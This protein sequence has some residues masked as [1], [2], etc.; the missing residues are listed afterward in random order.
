MDERP[1]TC[2]VETVSLK[3]G[4]FTYNWPAADCL[5][6]PLRS[7]F[8]QQLRPGVAMTSNVKSGLPIVLHFL[9]PLVLCPSEEPEPGRDDGCSCCYPWVGSHLPC[10]RRMPASLEARGCVA[11]SERRRGLHHTG[12]ASLPMHRQNCARTDAGLATVWVYGVSGTSWAMAPRNA[13]S[14]RA[15]A[16]TTWLAFCPRARSCR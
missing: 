9:R 15:I 16:T 2:G 3:A 13:R 4:L 6:R 7:R 1:R 8:R 5:Q 10:V 14:S 11:A 12:A